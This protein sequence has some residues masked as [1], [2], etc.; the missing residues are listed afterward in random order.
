MGIDFLILMK[1]EWAVIAILFILL[2][3]KVGNKEWKS[4]NILSL[5][6][7][8]LL[9]NFIA[10]LFWNQQGNLFN[11]MYKTNPLVVTEKNILSLVL[12]LCAAILF[13]AEK[14]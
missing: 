7:I 1:Q 5:V 10:G 8:L 11:E 2:F 3:I 13:L 14:P 12:T 6:N 9:F 4:D